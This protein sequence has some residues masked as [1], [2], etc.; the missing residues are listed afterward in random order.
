MR[1]ANLS[2]TTVLVGISTVILGTVPAQGFNIVYKD[3]LISLRNLE[4]LEYATPSGDKGKVWVDS[5][6]E[7]L[8]PPS[9][10]LLELFRQQFSDWEFEAFFRPVY[11]D[12]VVNDYRACPPGACGIGLLVGGLLDLDYLP[13]K[14]FDPEL[15]KEYNDFPDPTTGRVQWIQWVE[16]NHSLQGGHGVEERVLDTKSNTPFYYGER[17]LKNMND[18]NYFLRNKEVPIF[19]LTL[20]GEQTFGRITTG[21]PI[22]TWHIKKKKIRAKF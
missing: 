11:G 15:G 9:G 3:P 21:L 6:L 16:N 13:R 5:P 22:S 19:S 20:L 7:K 14:F 17:L 2:I 18:P 4:P 10:E 12:F 8:R 1:K